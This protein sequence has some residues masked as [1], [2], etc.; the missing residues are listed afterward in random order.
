MSVSLHSAQEAEVELCHPGS[1]RAHTCA[2][3]AFLQ[4]VRALEQ[5][6]IL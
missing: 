6:N 3:L 4:H 2:L 1:A 5:C